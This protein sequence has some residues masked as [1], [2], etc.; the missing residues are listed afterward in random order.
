MF[1]S[2]S[3]KNGARSPRSRASSTIGE[4]TASESSGVLNDGRPAGDTPSGNIA[5]IGPVGENPSHRAASGAGSIA[6]PSLLTGI[7]PGGRSS[8]SPVGVAASARRYASDGHGKRQPS[9]P[10]GLQSGAIGGAALPPSLHAAV[11]TRTRAGRKLIQPGN[12]NTVN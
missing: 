10:S 12:P 4:P 7:P 1:W 8:R 11:A 9:P 3:A 5:R 2:I 6:T